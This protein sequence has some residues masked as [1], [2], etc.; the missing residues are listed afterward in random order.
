MQ[1]IK[2]LN[3]S[4]AHTVDQ[5][6]LEGLFLNSILKEFMIIAGLGSIIGTI[7]GMI[8]SNLLDNWLRSYYGVNMSFVYLTPVTL[9]VCFV[10]LFG[11]VIL[12]SL[13]PG[14]RSTSTDIQKGLSLRADR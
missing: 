7:P 5:A 1:F 11:F 3:H 13:L 10:F 4:C 8:G 12:F 2:N 9:I 6:I 14:Y